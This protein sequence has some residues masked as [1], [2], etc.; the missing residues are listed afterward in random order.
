MLLNVGTLLMS[1]GAS[2]GR[3]RTMILEKG[4]WFGFAALGFA[5]PMLISRKE[6]VKKIKHKSDSI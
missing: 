5:I 3:V 6:T 4:I 1:N 2:T